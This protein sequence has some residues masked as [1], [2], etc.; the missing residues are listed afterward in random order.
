MKSIETLDEAIKEF[1]DA[2]LIDVITLNI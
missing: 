2:P 1:E